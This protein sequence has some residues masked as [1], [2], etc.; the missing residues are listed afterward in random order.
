MVAGY[1]DAMRTIS[2][3]SVVAKLAGIVDREATAGG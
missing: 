1:Q 3:E 2:P